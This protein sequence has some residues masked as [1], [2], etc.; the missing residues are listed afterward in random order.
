M[1][2]TEVTV[3]FLPGRPISS[4]RL[5]RESPVEG[6]KQREIN[7]LPQKEAQKHFL[8]C[9][10]TM[11]YI[12]FE[13]I[14]QLEIHAKEMVNLCG[15]YISICAVFAE[16]HCHTATKRHDMQIVEYSNYSFKVFRTL[17]EIF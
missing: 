5:K 4:E 2:Q 9:Q 12:A 13:A 16:L 6:R 1:K 10:K 17:L 8:N 14:F 7:I 11:P 3:C 15:S